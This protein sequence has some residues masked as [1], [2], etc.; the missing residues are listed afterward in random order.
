M[1]IH[2]QVNASFRPEPRR[3]TGEEAIHELPPALAA[4]G[5][6]PLQS[7]LLGPRRAAAPDLCVHG[8][9]RR[10]GRE[11]PDDVELPLDALE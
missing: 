1:A 6:E 10:E 5:S 3:R 4:A 2:R 7:Y 8:R 11:E 9:G